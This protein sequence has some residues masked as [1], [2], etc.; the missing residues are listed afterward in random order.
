MN[1]EIVVFENC[2]LDKNNIK[3]TIQYLSQQILRNLKINNSYIEIYVIGSR[4]INAMKKKFLRSN[5]PATVLS[6]QAANFPH[7]QTKNRPLGEIYLNK[8][9]FNDN[10]WPKFLIHGILH[11]LGY[12]HHQ[13]NDIIKMEKLENKIW[14]KIS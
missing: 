9:I 4:K 3:K 7:P 11:L 5:K 10:V 6:F 14:D 13:K 8:N 2:Y 1:N 12:D